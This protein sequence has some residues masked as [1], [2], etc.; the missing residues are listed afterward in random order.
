MY[1]IESVTDEYRHALARL[2]ATIPSFVALLIDH[3]PAALRGRTLREIMPLAERRPERLLALLRRWE[4]NPV[5][6][7]SRVP[8]SLAFAALGQGRAVGLM[9]P[10]REARLLT[11]LLALWALR[12]T[13]DTSAICADQTL[14]EFRR[15][16]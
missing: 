15:A 7:M 11:E 13:L 1:P 14:P 16:S 4:T 5:A 8:P 12:T 3:R 6:A 2:A 9:S 10:E